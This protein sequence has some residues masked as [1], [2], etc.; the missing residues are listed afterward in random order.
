MARDWARKL[1]DN[2]G[3]DA[4]LSPI[5][6]EFLCGVVDRHEMS[7]AE[8]YLESFNVIDASRILVQD[9]DEARAIAKHIGP[10]SRPRGLGDCLIIALIRRLKYEIDTHD[11]GL[12]QQRGRTR[13][14]RP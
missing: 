9:W 3:S 1:I 5:V 6:I 8:A 2:K 11:K 4:I 7:L 13:Q 10:Q 14:R 12:H